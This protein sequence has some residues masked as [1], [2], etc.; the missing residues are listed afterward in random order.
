MRGR[1][2]KP[3]ALLRLHGNP[4][5]RPLPVDEPQPRQD[6][7]LSCPE[8]LDQEAKNEWQRMSV[9]LEALGLLTVVDRAALA[10][11]CQCYSRWVKLEGI[12]QK[13]GEVLF[14]KISGQHYPSPYMGALNRALKNMQMFASEFGLSPSSR[15]RIHVTPP[16][17][18]GIMQR[19]RRA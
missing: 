16:K 1:K 6:K 11:Y 7:N 14:N 10:A 18:L 2:P 5:K 4:G 13:T 8:H 9:E 17:K 19:D 12:V 3:T 15:T